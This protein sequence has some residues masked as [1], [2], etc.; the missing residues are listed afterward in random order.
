MYESWLT[1]AYDDDDD[2]DDD[3]EGGRVDEAV[4]RFNSM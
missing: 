4:N 2:D 1:Y 3:D